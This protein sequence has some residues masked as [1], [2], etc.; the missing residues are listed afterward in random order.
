MKIT[1]EM[2]YR[3]AAEARDI[4]L[5][6]LPDDNEIPE[7]QFSDKF[8]KEMDR[9]ITLSH[10]RKQPSRRLQRIAAMFAVIIIGASSFIGVNA[11]ARATFFGWIK[12]LT[13]DYLIYRYE[14]EPVSDAGPASNV[15]SLAYLPTWIPEGYSKSFV[16]DKTNRTVVA[17]SNDA[18]ELIRLSYIYNSGETDWFISTENTVK[19]SAT[20]NGNKA[21]LFISTDPDTSGGVIW[22]DQSNTVFM[23]TGFLDVDDLLKMAESIQPVDPSE[24]E[25]NLVEPITDVHYG[26]TAIPEGYVEVLADYDDNGGSQLFE[27]EAGQYLTFLYTLNTGDSSMYIDTMSTAHYQTLFNG[28]EADMLISDD[29]A[30]Q[31]SMAWVDDENTV[32]CVMGFFDAD[33]LF[34]IAESIEPI[35]IETTTP[36]LS[37]LNYQPTLLPEGYTRHREIDSSGS[38]LIYYKNEAGQQLRYHYVYDTASTAMFTVAEGG[39]H[40]IIDI[41]GYQADMLLFDDPET[42]NCILWTDENNCAHAVHAFLDE[43]D[44]IKLAESVKIVEG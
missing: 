3:H 26:L 22:V 25:N 18:G 40:S 37:S 16:N 2:L 19:E 31:S 23:L 44:L 6:T 4:W 30:I 13:D 20:V 29:P 1:D 32:F 41:N 27:N 9:L 43:K 10:K 34:A 36:D 12:E 14:E 42:S 28:H 38:R 15:E 21:D 35:A 8:N 5:D 39:T 24:L 17:Y 11:E 33:G 7:H